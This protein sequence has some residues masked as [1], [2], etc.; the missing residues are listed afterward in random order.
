M[1]VV[2]EG[3]V[4]A[5]FRARNYYI[6]LSGSEPA[7]ALNEEW[8]ATVYNLENKKYRVFDLELKQTANTSRPLILSEY[9]YGGLAFR[10]HQNWNDPDSVSFRTSE[11]YNRS[12]GNE[13]RARWSSMAGQVNGRKAGIAMFDYPAN[14]KSPQP[15]RIHPNIPY[16]VYTPPQLGKM[17]IKPGS[18]YVVQY[19][20]IVFDGEPDSE[21]LN[22]LWND[23]AY[24]PGV[25]VVLE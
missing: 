9:H 16:F 18:P 11:G 14:P 10:G 17:E 13:T 12:T 4:H 5:G 23:Y 21:E 22:R 2:W 19:R 15:V 8:K 1:D 24:P 20:Y 25:T 6:D 3:P 7:D